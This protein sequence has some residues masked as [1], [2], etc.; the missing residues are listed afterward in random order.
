[1]ETLCSEDTVVDTNGSCVAI[2]EPKGIRLS[3][4]VACK[5][6][7][8]KINSFCVQIKDKEFYSPAHL[9]NSRFSFLIPLTPSD[10]STLKNSLITV[11]PT[12]ENRRGNSFY[13]LYESTLPIPQQNEIDLIGGGDLVSISTHILGI[14]KRCDLKNS[15]HVL[16]VGCGLG[17]IAYSLAHFLKPTTKY[18]GF[19]IV[20]S[21]VERAQSNITSTFPNF[22]FQHVDLYNGMY[23]PTGSVLSCHFTFPYPDESFD[24]V[25]LTSV[26]TH[27]LP[28]DVKRYLKEIKRVL[29]P[30]GKCMTTAFLLNGHSRTLMNQGRGKMI[31][32]HPYGQCVTLDPSVIEGVV[33]YDQSLFLKWINSTGFKINNIYPGFWCDLGLEMDCVSF[34][35]L[36]LLT[37]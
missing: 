7:N 11:T 25:Y 34:Q 5:D 32:N 14:L 19:D 16:E 30:G 22:N 35:D 17:R 6:A 37:K 21:L 31:F 26:F 4:W 28:D 12:I 10:H 33:A 8:C 29:R 1:M 15:D 20:P 36:L 24:Y 13:C 9:N 3:G 23:N 18:E 27:M 2:G